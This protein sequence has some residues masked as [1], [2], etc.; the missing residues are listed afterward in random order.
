MMT[1]RFVVCL[2]VVVFKTSLRPPVKIFFTDQ[3]FVDPFL[4]FIFRVCHLFVSVQCSLV[5]TGR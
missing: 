4:L 3:S 1:G 5:V 2:F